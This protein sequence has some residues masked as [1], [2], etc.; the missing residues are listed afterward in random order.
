MNIK[1]NLKENNFLI[2]PQN[3]EKVTTQNV[4]S[5]ETKGN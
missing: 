5:L 2:D 1:T 4:S 3:P